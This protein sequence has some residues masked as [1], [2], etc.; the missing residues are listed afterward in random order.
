M[1]GGGEGRERRVL[2]LFIYQKNNQSGIAE[3]KV[4]S[5]RVTLN[6]M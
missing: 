3:I 6:Y 5:F 1:G 2:A 4:I